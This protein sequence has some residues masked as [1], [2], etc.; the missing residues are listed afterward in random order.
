MPPRSR[1]SAACPWA[2]R[3]LSDA[4]CLMRP[5]LFKGVF[6]R[7]KDYHNS[8]HYSPLLKNTRVRQVVSDVYVYVCIYIYIYIYTHTCIHIYIYIHIHT[9]IRS[10]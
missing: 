9:Y 7:V 4:T 10:T 3:C 5:R 2:W 8:Q 1:R 6:R